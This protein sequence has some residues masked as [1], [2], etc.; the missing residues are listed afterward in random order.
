MTDPLQMIARGVETVATHDIRGH[1]KKLIGG[2]ELDAV[3]VGYPK[4]LRNEPSES[5]RY[6][7]PFINSQS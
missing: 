2:L 1:L 7:D 6:I 5:V 4:T 3:V